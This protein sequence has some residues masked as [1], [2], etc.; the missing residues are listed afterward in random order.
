MLSLLLNLMCPCWIKALIYLLKIKQYKKILLTPNF[1]T[2]AYKLEIW[3]IWGVLGVY[4]INDE[5][6]FKV[7][8]G[9]AASH[10]FL[11]NAFHS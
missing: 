10:V 2:I 1:W 8:L 3:S 4:L 5:L 7:T 11:D 9:A 6:L